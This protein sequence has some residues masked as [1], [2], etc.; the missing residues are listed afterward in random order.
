MAEFIKGD[1]VVIP[2]PFSDLS[3]VK[4][5]PAF[6]IS[7]LEGDDVIL[8]QITSQTIKDKYSI[9]LRKTDFVVGNLLVNSNIRPNRIFTA[10][11]NIILYK[12]GNL[13]ENKIKETIQKIIKIINS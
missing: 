1:I 7:K 8:C 6:V 9:L 11:K 2:F 10:D 13:K 12:V 4:K 5:R 3:E